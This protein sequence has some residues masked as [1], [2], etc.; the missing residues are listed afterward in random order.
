MKKIFLFTLILITVSQLKIT[1]QE[2]NNLSQNKL[3]LSKVGLIGVTIGGSFIVNGTFPA[4]MTDRVDQFITRIYSEYKLQLPGSI[5]ESSAFIKY[6]NELESF[7]KRNIILKRFSGET[8]KVDLEKYRLTGDFK[9]NPYLKND[10][11]IIFPSVDM[12][13]N[14]IDVSGAV[15]KE[16]KFQFMEGDNLSDAILFAGG[17]N[18]AYENISKAEIS[19]LNLLGDKEEVIE[20]DLKSDFPLKR[21]DRIRI[22]FEASYRKNYKALVVG[23]INKPGYIYLTNNNT[24]IRELI[25]KAGGFTSK[26][27]L[28]MSELIR[29][30][31]VNQMFK[32]NAIRKEYE[33]NPNFDINNFQKE[34]N[35]KTLEDLQMLRMSDVSLED[36]LYF[37]IDNSLR[38]FQSRGIVD[39]TKI[40]SNDYNDRNFIVKD[41]DIILVPQKDDLVFVFGQVNNPGF[42]RYYQGK[43]FK[44]YLKAA[45]GLGEEADS[46]IKIIKG[47]TRSWFSADENVGIDSGDYI[48]V[49]KS[50]P[51]KFEWYLRQTGSLSS[52]LAAIATIILVIVQSGK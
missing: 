6:N 27:S 44:Y 3:D 51:K 26:A 28:G 32:L 7:A 15:N 13:T 19:R 12:N 18:P 35:V 17:L 25:E 34:F 2:I 41:G 21:G 37:L 20:V 23:E 52:V 14:F 4:V 48:Y 50:V 1:A 10:D 5:K 11:V 9:L 38:L 40:Y 33:K 47:K 42:T 8:E 31:D 16:V 46:D 43:D 36:S 22:P 39:F 24:T 45:G 29:S 49:P 30:T